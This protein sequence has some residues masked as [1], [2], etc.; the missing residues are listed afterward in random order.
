[1]IVLEENI[2]KETIKNSSYECILIE[3][4][5]LIPEED[6]LLNNENIIAAIKETGLLTFCLNELTNVNIP[7]QK[8]YYSLKLIKNIINSQSTSIKEHFFKLLNEENKFEN[9]IKFLEELSLANLNCR[10]KQEPFH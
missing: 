10:F 9:F 2:S 3:T 1:M 7:M 5:S 6:N 8:K 4:E